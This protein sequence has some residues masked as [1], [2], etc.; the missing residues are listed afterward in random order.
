MERT[1]SVL[2]LQVSDRV[3]TKAFTG[4]PAVKYSQNEASFFAARSLFVLVHDTQRL[5]DTK[6]LVADGMIYW[7]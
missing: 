6:N 4:S 3:T 7:T 5:I 2:S 1:M